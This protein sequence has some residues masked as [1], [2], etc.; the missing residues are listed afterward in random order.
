MSV[1]N[2]A[3]GGPV[4]SVGGVSIAPEGS[5]LPTD[6]TTALDA[7]YKPAGLVGN[8]GVTPGGERAVEDILDWAGD[9]VLSPQ[10]SH[11]VTFSFPLLDVFSV[12]VHKLAF[13][14]ENVTETPA[15]TTNGN[16]IA[17]TETGSEL[18]RK[19]IVFDLRHVD[20]RVRVVVP[21]AKVTTVEEGPWQ[22]GAP[23][24]FTITISGYKDE[25]GIKVYRY[26][27]DGETTAV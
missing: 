10:T 15:T 1:N 19:V 2:A 18:G 3:A 24:Q 16:Q 5:V 9:V 6:A 26:Y 13:G 17:V 11:S 14:D 4:T 27:D 8:D 23:Q 12:D 25:S 7:A 22:K 20:K 21:Q